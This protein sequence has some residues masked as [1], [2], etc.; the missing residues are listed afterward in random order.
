M[1]LIIHLYLVQRL[2]MNGV[3]PI[4]PY[5]PSLLT[6]GLYQRI[7]LHGNY[8]RRYIW[9]KFRSIRKVFPQGYHG[10]GLVQGYPEGG[11]S[12]CLQNRDTYVGPTS[13][14]GVIYRKNGKFIKN[15]HFLHQSCSLR[16]VTV[17]KNV[18]RRTAEICFIPL[19][20]TSVSQPL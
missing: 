14:H 1:K 15:F 5:M 12:T 16:D 6:Q 8:A 2:R 17:R 10:M 4:L 9:R 13:L 19:C 20:Y 3:G 18:G 11:S 7:A